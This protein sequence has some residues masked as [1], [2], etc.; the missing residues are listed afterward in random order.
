YSIWNLETLLNA[1][2]VK[3]IACIEYYPII[4]IGNNL[5]NAIEY[6]IIISK[7]IVFIALTNRMD[8]DFLY[9]LSIKFSLNLYFHT[10]E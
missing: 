7:A 10:L 6:M 9:F 1:C 4:E 5:I 2:P 3:P 8:G